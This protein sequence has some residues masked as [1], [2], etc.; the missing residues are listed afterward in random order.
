MRS[1]KA[2][3]SS[4]CSLSVQLP[5]VEVNCKTQAALAPSLICT[6][7]LV[8]CA[9]L[10]QL[11]FESSIIL[12]WASNCVAS[13]WRWQTII[14]KLT[15]IIYSHNNYGCYWVHVKCTMASTNTIADWMST[16]A[17][18]SLAVIPYRY[19]AVPV[20]ILLHTLIT[21]PLSKL[22]NAQ[23]PLKVGLIHALWIHDYQS[24]ECNVYK[25]CP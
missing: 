3:D 24:Q 16:S 13:V 5:A 17:S 19:V 22:R 15:T 7:L 10:P 9:Y 8:L 12:L 2:S 21:L 18:S 20:I 4:V 6:C 23:L 14:S 1:P 25:P 11:L